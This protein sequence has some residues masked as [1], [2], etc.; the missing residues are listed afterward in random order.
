VPRDII[1]S[2]RVPDDVKEALRAKAKREGKTMSDLVCEACD[3]KL[4]VY[5]MQS[6]TFN[7]SAPDTEQE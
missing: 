1:V 4:M 6:N 3:K 5:H 2:V 7:T